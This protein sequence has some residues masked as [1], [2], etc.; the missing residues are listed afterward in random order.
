M[1]GLLLALLFLRHRCQPESNDQ[2]LCQTEAPW[3]RTGPLNIEDARITQEE[4]AWGYSL[5]AHE[6]EGVGWHTG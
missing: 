1:G 3:A 4:L 6:W 5:C 2:V